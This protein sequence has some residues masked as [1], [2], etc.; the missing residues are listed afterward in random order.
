MEAAHADAES[1]MLLR[2]LPRPTHP[3]RQAHEHGN[4]RMMM[5]LMDDDDNDDDD[6]YDA[7]DG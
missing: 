2:V 1:V 6:D 7:D 5:M 4:W 3:L